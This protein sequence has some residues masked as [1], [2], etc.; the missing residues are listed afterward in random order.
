VRQSLK[1]LVAKRRAEAAPPE[2]P[3]VER[4]RAEAVIQ[5]DRSSTITRAFVADTL[6]DGTVT[7]MLAIRDV[8][9]GQLTIPA[10]RF[11]LAEIIKLFDELEPRP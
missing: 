8:G 3:E 7:I 11:E 6:A 1:D 4:R 10:G 5:L 2:D 9:S